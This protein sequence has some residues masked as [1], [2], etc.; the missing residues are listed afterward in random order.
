MRSTAE[1][2]CRSQKADKRQGDLHYFYPLNII[3]VTVVGV[4][5]TTE[6]SRSTPDS[7]D[8]SKNLFAYSNV[9][10]VDE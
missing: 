6:S 9:V 8:D 4:I 7:D 5:L 10:H 1:A 2:R 3:I